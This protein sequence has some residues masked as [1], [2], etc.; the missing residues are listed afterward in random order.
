[1]ALTASHPKAYDALTASQAKA[2]DALTASQAKAYDAICEGG[3]VFLTGAGGTGKSFLIEYIKNNLNHKRIAV[4]ALTGCAALLLGCGAKTLHSWAGIGLGKESAEALAAKIKKNTRARKSWR[5]SDI[6]IID[7]ISM[8][9]A[10]LFDKLSLIAQ[11]VRGSTRSF[12]GLQL[13]LV[14]DFFQLPPIEVS[15]TGRQYVFESDAWKAAITT[16][17]ELE[18][19][20]R[21]SDPQFKAILNEARIG[22][23]SEEH[24]A[25][26]NGRK[27]LNWKDNQI[28]PTLLF[29]RRAEVDT[30]NETNLKSLSG[31]FHT[32]NANL[33]N[34]G[35]DCN[36]NLK[37]PNLLYDVEQ[38]DKAAQ[39]QGTLVLAEG[40]QV[41]LIYNLDMEMGLVNGSRGVVVGFQKGKG[42]T[43]CPRVMFKDTT[44]LIDENDWPLENYPGVA[45]RQIPLILAYAQTIHKCQGSTLDSALIDIGRRTFEYGQ[46]YVALSRVKSLDSLYIW[47]LNPSAFKVHAKVLEFYDGIRGGAVAEAAKVP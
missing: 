37:D 43:M 27:G 41:M 20:K 47:D 31:P 9:P 34:V 14:G 16:T 35:A 17:I 21:Q 40:A 25:V 1:M 12:G 4:T 13:I 15:P 38:M 2:Y 22:R 19:V 23:I 24:L 28:K 39:Y 26:L 42:G 10:D 33:L 36:Y 44:R 18:E 32:Y 8:M 5:Q 46:A 11:I 3:N 6:L 45:R 29:S 7:E 30:I